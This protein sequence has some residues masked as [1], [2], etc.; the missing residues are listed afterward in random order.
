MVVNKSL[1]TLGFIIRSAS[2]FDN[3]TL[4]YLYKTLARSVLLFNSQIW[5]PYYDKYIVKLESVQHKFFRYLAY[6]MGMPFSY[7]DH[8]YF[9]FAKR[10]DLCSIKSLHRYYDLLFV[11][12]VLHCSSSCER[13]VLSSLFTYRENICIQY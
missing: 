13:S 10:V 8:S 12:K 1:R 5:S 6:R 9:D 11:R 7:D 4:I 2:R 3:A